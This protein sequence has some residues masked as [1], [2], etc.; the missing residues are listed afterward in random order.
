MI[1]QRLLISHSLGPVKI[2]KNHNLINL[3]AEQN[4]IILLS[5]MN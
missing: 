2:E 5:S 4:E 3:I 1:D